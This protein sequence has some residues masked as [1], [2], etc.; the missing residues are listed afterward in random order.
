MSKQ[1]H[2]R[3]ATNLVR[4]PGRKAVDIKLLKQYA[5]YWRV[6]LL[7][8][9]DG[10]PGTIVEQ[11]KGQKPIARVEVLRASARVKQLLSKLEDLRGGPGKLWFQSPVFPEAKI[12]DQIKDARSATEMQKALDALERFSRKLCPRARWADT[13]WSRVLGAVRDHAD[14]LVKA[15]ELPHYP[16]SSRR[17]TSDDKRIEFFAKVMAGL[18]LRLAPLGATKRLSHWNPDKPDVAPAP[19][20][21]KGPNCPH[22]GTDEVPGFPPH[23]VVRCPGCDERYYIASKSG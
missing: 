4:R 21:A 19:T 14:D 18:A 22:C 10:R 2:N 23:T 16:K 7:L 20:W 12:W 9:R 6:H 3:I 8:L 5:E 17:K 11:G 1:I 15:K 13:F